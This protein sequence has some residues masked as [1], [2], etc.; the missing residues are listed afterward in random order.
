MVR[1][2]TLL[3]LALITCFSLV[4]CAGYVE[5]PPTYTTTDTV[6]SPSGETTTSETVRTL[7]PMY[8]YSGVSFK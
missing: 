7:Y 8:S 1:K 2:L 6:V 5:N 3:S 4:G